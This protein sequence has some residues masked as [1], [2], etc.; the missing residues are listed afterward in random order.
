MY[1]SKTY[2]TVSYP[3]FDNSPLRNKIVPQVMVAML[4]AVQFPYTTEG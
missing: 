2:P 1:P 3:V 4:M